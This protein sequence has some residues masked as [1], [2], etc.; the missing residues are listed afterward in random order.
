MFTTS[1]CRISWK[2]R[3]SGV[4]H[5]LR[6][7]RCIDDVYIEEWTEGRTHITGLPA[8]LVV[9]HAHA[10]EQA[11]AVPAVEEEDGAVVGMAGRSFSL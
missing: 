10:T 3:K 4:R 6:H 7:P 11:D 5:A 8:L 2:G 9:R 1:T